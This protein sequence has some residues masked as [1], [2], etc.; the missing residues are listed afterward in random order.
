ML[1]IVFSSNF[2]LN[3]ILTHLVLCFGCWV[4]CTLVIHDPIKFEWKN[5]RFFSRGTTEIKDFNLS[6]VFICW[7]N[8]EKTLCSCF[9]YKGFGSL[10]IFLHTKCIYK[11]WN[12]ISFL[13]SPTNS[14]VWADNLKISDWLVV[15]NPVFT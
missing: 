9:Q 3:K 11:S 7:G 2:V 13:R 6:M 4:P 1:L 8:W 14:G 12:L 10:T 15:S 5:A